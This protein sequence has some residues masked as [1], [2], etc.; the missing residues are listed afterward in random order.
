MLDDQ[1]KEK[2][3][4]ILKLLKSKF[5]VSCDR[6][7]FDLMCREALECCDFFC[8]L[9]RGAGRIE[10]ADAEGS[11]QSSDNSSS[12]VGQ[13]SLK[14][15][16]LS[17]WDFAYSLLISF[18]ATHDFGDSVSLFGLRVCAGIARLSEAV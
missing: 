16:L 6:T 15:S 2:H 11:G 17:Y 5:A 3:E 4:Y 13:S 18:C 10:K 7:G 14:S 12:A 9:Q 8:K 1:R